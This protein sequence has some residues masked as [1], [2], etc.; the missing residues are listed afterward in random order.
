M[1]LEHVMS[2]IDING[3]T[4]PNRI[5]R[6]PH[7]TH[8]L[9]GS[10]A[11]DLIAYHEMR[12]KGGVGLTILEIISVHP[13]SP[14]PLNSHD[15]SIIPGYEKLMATI[16]P[17]GMKVF[18]QLWHGGGHGM[19]P[20]GGPAWGPSPVPSVRSGTVPVEMTKDQIADVVNGF[21]EA[22]RRCEEGGLDGVEIHGCHGFLVHQFTSP[23]TNN[24]TDEYGG[25]FENRA[26]FL[27][28][29]LTAIRSKVS[30][31]FAVGVRLSA[32]NIKGGLTPEDNANLVE[33]LTAAGNLDYVSASSGGFYDQSAMIGAMHEPVG[34]MYRDTK[35]MIEACKKAGIPVLSTGRYRTLEEANQAISAGEGDL[36]GM[37]RATIADPDLVRK[38]VEGRVD[39]VRP[40]IGCN[41][42]CAGGVLTLP[43][44]LRCTVNPAIGKERFIGEDKLVPVDSPKKVLVIGG[45]PAGMEAARVAA[46]RGHQVSLVEAS[47][48][49]GGMVRFARK[50]PRHQGIGDIIDWQESEIYR[51][52]VDVKLSTYF[53]IDDILAENADAIVLAA[54]STPRLDGIQGAR[55]GE[56]AEGMDQPH[57]MTAVD[58]LMNPPSDVGASALVLDDVGHYEAI[59]A[60]EYLI[61]RGVAVTYVTRYSGLAE[62]LEP[63]FVTEPALRRLR[64]GDFTLMSR[65]HVSTIREKEVDVRYLDGG[66]VQTI[67]AETVIF[68]T[69]HT[70]NRDLV[71]ELA[72]FAGDVHVVGDANSPRLL[73]EALHEGYHAGRAI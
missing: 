56:P 33:M 23:L 45:G 44:L 17:H 58:L 32:E 26:R 62:R 43:P 18:Q 5:V 49:L 3:V 9:R 13:S 2:P 42:E 19:H 64:Q 15:D 24:R 71:G 8:F 73:P 20:D 46:M 1:A 4:L 14:G 29:I 11:D 40:C 66:P 34:Y 72:D 52:G 57:V 41:Q 21:A 61:E 16:R 55:P 48:N 22:S 51:L 28:E 59:G 7:G 50:A 70:P 39:E 54:G 63:A 37:N 53:E 38:T 47:P 60:A 27:K 10:I 30:P 67:P 36:I 12:A 69:S 31:G 35:P 65:A 6:P 25:S 68:V